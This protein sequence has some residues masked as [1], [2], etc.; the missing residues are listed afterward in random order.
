MTTAKNAGRIIAVLLLAQ[1]VGGPVVNFMLLQPL[2]STSFLDNAAAHSLDISL[3][4]LI[5][6]A[7]GAATVGIAIAAFPIV[8]D[9]SQAMA[10]WLVALAIF[11]LSVCAIENV[12]VLSMVSL[13]RDYASAANHD[14]FALLATMAS[15]AR[16]WAHYLGLIV[17]GSFAFVLYATLYRFSLIPRLLAGFGM[18]AA[19]LEIIAVA[20]PL[21]ARPVVFPMIAPLGLAHL[22]L[23]IWLLVKGFAFREPRPA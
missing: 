2:A 23:A 9:H 11:G 3:G 12:N 10:L 5:A 15:S 19:L 14:P 7:M 22:A 1:M 17:A 20:M 18:I 21:F 13:S 6:L 4:V 8:R 16:K